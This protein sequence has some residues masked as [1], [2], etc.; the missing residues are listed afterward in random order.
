MRALNGGGPGGI[1]GDCE[2]K[3]V[4]TGD[5]TVECS[6]SALAF[7]SAARV[8]SSG[9]SARAPGRTPKRGPVGMGRD[10]RDGGAETKGEV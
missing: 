2:C 1:T 10:A 4:G 6:A 7:A 3:G 8:A 5:D 9:M